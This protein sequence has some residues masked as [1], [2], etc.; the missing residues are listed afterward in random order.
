M[1]QVLI[2]LIILLGA[3]ID[4]FSQRVVLETDVPTLEK[5]SIEHDGLIGII[6]IDKNEEIIFGNDYTMS[7]IVWM[8]KQKFLK[9]LAVEVGIEKFLEKK[10][11][12]KYLENRKNIRFTNQYRVDNIMYSH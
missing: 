10:E 6:D 7:D 2:F 8:G 3:T 1:K 12:K 4:V 5:E 9:E 11:L